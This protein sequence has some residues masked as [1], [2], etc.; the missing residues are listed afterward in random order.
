MIA[1]QKMELKEQLNNSNPN[2]VSDSC[3]ETGTGNSNEQQT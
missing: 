3:F 1:I 2:M